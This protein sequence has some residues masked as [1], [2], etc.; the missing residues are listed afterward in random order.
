MEKLWDNI[1]DVGKNKNLIQTSRTGL[2]FTNILHNEGIKETV[3]DDIKRSIKK[4][5]KET[6]RIFN[7]T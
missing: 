2:T 3:Y 7:E 6:L 4:I 1:Y 5:I